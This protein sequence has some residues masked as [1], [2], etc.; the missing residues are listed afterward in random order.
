M[1]DPDNTKR[2]QMWKVCAHMLPDKPCDYYSFALSR[3]LDGKN[4][5]GYQVQDLLEGKC[6]FC[7]EGKDIQTIWKHGKGWI[8]Q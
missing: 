1:C 8:S 4:L 2:V 3:C 6:R 7:R 5:C